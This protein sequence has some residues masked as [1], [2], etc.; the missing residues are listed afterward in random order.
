MAKKLL[1]FAMGVYATCILSI[2]TAGECEFSHKK[3]QI[4]TH[5][6][7]AHL[8]KKMSLKIKLNIYSKSWNSKKFKYGNDFKFFLLFSEF[9][10]DE[11]NTK[12]KLTWNL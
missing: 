11:K 6:Y 10:S 5:T 1:G 4:C 8:Y 3:T 7:K 9:G 12:L 2:K